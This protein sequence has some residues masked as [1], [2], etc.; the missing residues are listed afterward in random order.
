MI[1][2]T[3]GTTGG[4]KGVLHSHNTLH[5]LIQQIRAHWLVESGDK[6]LIPSPIGHVGGSIYAF[7]CPLLLGTTAVLMDQW[8]AADAIRLFEREGCTHMAGATPFL[9][10]LLVAAESAGTKLPGLKLFVCGGASVPPSLI[11]AAAGYFERAVVTRVYGSTEV[12]VTTVGATQPGEAAMGADTDGRPGLADVKIVN[13]EGLSD[14][15]GEILV[16]GPQMLVGYLHFEHEADAFDADG[17][18]RSGDLGQWVDERYLVVIGRA[19]DLIIRNGENIS[20]K[21]IEDLLSGHPD[22]GE[23]A[24][25]GLPDLRT[26]ERTCAV[27]VSKDSRTLTVE[28]LQVFLRE[29]GLAAFKWPEQVIYWDALPKNAAGKIMKQQIRGTLTAES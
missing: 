26:G 20:P 24:V 21:E 17:Y 5:A 19:K 18:Y 27:I 8:N 1:L 12:P 16:R 14:G 25:V 11:R 15:S 4:A 10:Q 9:Q 29:L 3:S 7:E 2:Y 28:D 13:R 6:F 22:I 23:V